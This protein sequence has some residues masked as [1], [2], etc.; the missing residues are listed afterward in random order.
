MALT[1][2]YFRTIWQCIHTCEK[3]FTTDRRLAHYI[4]VNFSCQ[5]QFERE[6][7]TFRATQICRPVDRTDICGRG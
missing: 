3:D 7:C 4:G 5:F 1:G 2:T 6:G